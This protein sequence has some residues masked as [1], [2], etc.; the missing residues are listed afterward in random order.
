MRYYMHVLS[1]AKEGQDEEFNRWYDSTHIHDVCALDWVHSGQRFRLAKG[2]DAPYLA[3]YEVEADSP[4][5]ILPKLGAAAATME[6]SDAL[7]V[8][9]VA[10]RIF[11]A[12]QPVA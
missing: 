5:E 11:E 4:D 2:A 6:K 3:I 8:S 12:H 9:S 10:F 1:A 7:D